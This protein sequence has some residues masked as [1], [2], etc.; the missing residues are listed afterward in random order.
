MKREGSSLDEQ[1][2]KDFALK[3]GPVYAHPRRVFFVE[4]LPLS[5]T[6]KIDR[7][8]LEAEAVEKARE[9]EGAI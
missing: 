1:A 7:R 8:A 3:N 9:D 5:G 6:N 4:A 2:V